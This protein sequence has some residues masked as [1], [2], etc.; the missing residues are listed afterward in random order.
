MD[1][2]AKKN[3]KNKT[4]YYLVNPDFEEGLA[5]AMT[6]GSKKYGD[7]NYRNLPPLGL[8]RKYYSALRRHVY[9]CYSK[10]EKW[11][12]VTNEDEG[13]TELVRCA[14]LQ[15]YEILDKE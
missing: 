8:K 5:R 3:D 14:K 15:L 6:Y 13:E 1:K 4:K 9:A 12:F 7:F 2:K 10:K 11:I